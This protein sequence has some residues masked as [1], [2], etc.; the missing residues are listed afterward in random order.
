MIASAALG[1]EPVNQKALLGSWTC[2][3][4]VIDGKSLATETAKELRLTLTT[5]RYKTERGQ[6]V[7]FDS[8]YKLDGEKTP[9]QIDMIG[10]EGDLKGKAALGILQFDGETLTMCYVMP[11]KE[12]PTTFESVPESGVF[13]VVWKRTQ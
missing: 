11:G 2:S 7:L 9:A 1:A 5:D 10:T 12:R 6:Q 8:T 4:A 3:S 13:L